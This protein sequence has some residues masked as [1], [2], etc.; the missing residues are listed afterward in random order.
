MQC[1]KALNSESDIKKKQYNGAL[2]RDINSINKGSRESNKGE[3][4]DVKQLIELQ[5]KLLMD[6]YNVACLDVK[7]LKEVLNV[8]ETNVYQMLRKNELL[9]VNIG[10]RKVVPI[11]ALAKYLVEGIDVKK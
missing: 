10:R 5:S 8:G 2:F 11:I 6:K 4:V 9:V 3:A 1:V 7:Q